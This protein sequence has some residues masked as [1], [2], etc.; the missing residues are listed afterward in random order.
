MTINDVLNRYG[1]TRRMLSERFGIPYPTVIK[2]CF[3]TDNPNHRDC[4]KYII[5]MIDV[6]LSTESAR[7]FA[8]INN[9]L[10][11]KIAEANRDDLAEDEIINNRFL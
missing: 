6:I 1:Y 4:P 11:Q 2:W 3:P 7:Q 9:I 5:S 10:N 8:V